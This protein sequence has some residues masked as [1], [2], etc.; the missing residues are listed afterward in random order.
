MRQW[1]CVVFH[2]QFHLVFGGVCPLRSPLIIFM[3]TTA[4]CPGSVRIRPA[5]LRLLVW[6]NGSFWSRSNRIGVT[7]LPASF[8]VIRKC[9]PVLAAFLI[10]M[11][12][13]IQSRPRNLCLPSSTESKVLIL[14]VVCS[15]ISWKNNRLVAYRPGLTKAYSWS[16]SDEIMFGSFVHCLFFFRL[17]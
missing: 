5:V 4:S 15:R 2:Y 7:H 14:S 9:P 6:V 8:S 13:V 11:W 3:F 17:W 16:P 1:F 12:V 10:V